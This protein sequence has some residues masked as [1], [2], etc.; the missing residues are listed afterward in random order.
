MNKSVDREI[1]SDIILFTVKD[2]K[3]IFGC[4]INQ[5]YQIVHSGGFPKIQ[6]GNKFYIPK[7]KFE[8]WL[9]K[10]VGKNIVI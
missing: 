3:E 2:I 4:G 10:N 1:N 9:D 6:I 5:A 7:D 8:K